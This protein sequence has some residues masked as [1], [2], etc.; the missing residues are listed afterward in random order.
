MQYSLRNVWIWYL[1][2]NRIEEQLSELSELQARIEEACEQKKAA[3]VEAEGFAS[4]IREF[5]ADK[6]QEQLDVLMQTKRHEDQL[7]KIQEDMNRKVRSCSG[8]VFSIGRRRECRR[9]STCMF[10]AKCISLL[11]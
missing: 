7:S 5:E 1:E 6:T 8:I 4:R 3:Q 10:H 2:T 9:F 11:T